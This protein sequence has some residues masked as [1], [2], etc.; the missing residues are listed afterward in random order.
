MRL[1]GLEDKLV[2]SFKLVVD[3]ISSGTQEFMNDIDRKE[4]IKRN[5]VGFGVLVGQSSRLHRAY[6]CTSKTSG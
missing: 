6:S 2:F 5:Q 3:V 1:S 4:L